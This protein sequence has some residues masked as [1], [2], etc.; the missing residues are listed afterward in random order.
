MLIW[1]YRSRRCDSSTLCVLGFRDFL[2]FLELLL[3]FSC[4]ELQEHE[5]HPVVMVECPTRK[6]ACNIVHFRQLRHI[7]N[8][9][10]PAAISEAV[11]PNHNFDT[12]V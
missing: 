12:S 4:L 7:A 9:V 1:Y 3:H 6:Y 11:I 8:T 5:R 10:S 2:T